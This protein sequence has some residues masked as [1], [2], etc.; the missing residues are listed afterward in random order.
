MSLKLFTARCSVITLVT[1]SAFGIAQAADT[2]SPLP[3]A[4]AE[5][6]ANTTPNSPNTS[7]APASPSRGAISDK[8]IS[9][10]IKAALDANRINGLRVKTEAGIVT[11]AGTVTSED[12]RLKAAHIAAAVDGVRSVEFAGVTVKAS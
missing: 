7:N 3:Q 12:V 6:P 2:A 1:A 8:S 10:Q 4:P 9:S 5:I 11:L